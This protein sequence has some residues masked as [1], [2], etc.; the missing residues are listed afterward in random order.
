MFLF[1]PHPQSPLSIQWLTLPCQQIPSAAHIRPPETEVGHVARSIK[2]CTRLCIHSSITCARNKHLR[3]QWGEKAW[4]LHLRRSQSGGQMGALAQG[5]K[6]WGV[7][8]K[9]GIMEE[10]ASRT[11]CRSQGRWHEWRRGLHGRPS[12]SSS[13]EQ[14][15]Q[16]TR[17]HNASV[18]M[19]C[20][21]VCSAWHVVKTQ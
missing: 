3:I 21:H 10:G 20:G 7:D 11:F 4:P 15:Q 19:K 1:S 13:E 5:G 9:R 14:A 12:V 8:P 2:T 16:Q 17:P 18:K 6:S